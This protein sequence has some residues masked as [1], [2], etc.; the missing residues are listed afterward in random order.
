VNWREERMKKE[1]E[2]EERGSRWLAKEKEKFKGSSV[3]K[4]W[5]D[6]S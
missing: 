6:D 4:R 3:S 2:E 5:D 1:K